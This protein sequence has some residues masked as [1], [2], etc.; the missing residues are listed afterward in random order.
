MKIYKNEKRIKEIV[1]TNFSL[2]DVNKSG[3]VDFTG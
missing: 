3:K 2:V 1:E